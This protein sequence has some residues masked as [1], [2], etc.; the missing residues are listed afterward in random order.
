MLQSA[1]LIRG[2]LQKF[3]ASTS[4]DLQCLQCSD[5]KLRNL[6]DKAKEGSQKGFIVVSKILYKIGHKNY[7]ILCVPELLYRQIVSDSHSR[8]GF[9]FKTNQLG[10][11]LR[12]L[13]YHPNLQNMILDTS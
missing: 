10:P 5:V 11:I 2:L 9:H 12:P 4:A 7:K 6:Y 3:F 1:T 8:F 13:I